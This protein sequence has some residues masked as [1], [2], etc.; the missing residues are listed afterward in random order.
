MFLRPHHFQ[1]GRGHLLQQM[2]I[3]QSWDSHYNWGLRAIEIDM[4]ALA[5]FRLVVRSLRA[6]LRDGTLIDA[7]DGPLPDIDLKPALER[8]SVLTVLLAVPQLREGYANVGESADSEARYLVDAVDL[9]DENTGTNPQTL[10]VRRLNTRLLLSTQD[11]TGFAT[12]PLVKIERSDRAEGLPQLHAPPRSSPMFP[13]IPPLL[14]CEAWKPLAAEV[15]QSV[16]DRIGTKLK[17]LKAQVA[18]RNITFG[19]QAGRDALIFAQMCTLNEAYALL[20]VMVFAEGV[21]P[22]PAYLELCRLVGQLAI[23]GVDRSTPELPRYDHDDLGGC[24]YRVKN[25]I[26]A[27]LDEIIEPD[28]KERAFVGAGL[29]MQ[30]T[31]EPDWFAP[32]NQMFVGVHSSLPADK[33][34]QLFKAG[35]GGLDMKI[36]SSERVDAI[37]QTGRAGLAFSHCPTPPRALPG[38]S[39]IAYFQINRDAQK[40][41]WEQ[42]HKELTL[43]IRLNERLIVG[44]ITGEKALTVRTGAQTTTMQFTLFVTRGDA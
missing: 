16:Y 19:S 22:F 17:L 44:K 2:A 8:E 13:Y 18:S 4:D 10:E 15:L 9:V 24:F 43:A 39:D 1:A 21:H 41:E 36:A 34:V 28:Y 31:L 11:A 32:I 42:V 33:C 27:M 3:G 37:H 26:D 23:Y 7:A 40:A 12:L 6:R 29:R 5:N 35:P 20:G 14:A 38:G 30:V 25:Y